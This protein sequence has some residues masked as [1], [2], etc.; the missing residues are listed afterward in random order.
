MVRHG[1]M[2]AIACGMALAGLVGCGALDNGKRPTLEGE[3]DVID[4]T[5]LNDIMLTMANPEEAVAHFRA[6]LIREPEN[7]EFMRGL[8]TSLVRA[9]QP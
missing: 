1:L 4:A 8:A 9:K 5:G 2:R 3:L 7:P 6:A